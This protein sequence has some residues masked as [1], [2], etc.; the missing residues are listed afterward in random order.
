MMDFYNH[1]ENKISSSNPEDTSTFEE[2]CRN[3]YGWTFTCDENGRYTDCSEEI[4]D[5]LGFSP[6]VFL[7]EKF[8]QTYL[9][10]ESIDQIY[11]ALSSNE[12]PAVVPTYFVDRR[13]EQIPVTLTLMNDTQNNVAGFRGF[14]QVVL[15]SEEIA[16]PVTGGE[17]MV[18]DPVETQYSGT[19]FS[20]TVAYT[21]A[22]YQQASV[23]L[24]ELLEKLQ[25]ITPSIKTA[26]R[27]R[28]VSR[29][30]ISKYAD[31]TALPE[32]TELLGKE[33]YS[34]PEVKVL[35]VEHRLEWG[36]KLGLSNSE[37]QYI[38]EHKYINGIVGRFRVRLAP[39][40][41]LLCRKQWIQ[42]TLRIEHGIRD[43]LI[44]NYGNNQEQVFDNVLDLLITE[45]ETLLPLLTTILKKPQREEKIAIRGLDYLIPA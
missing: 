44:L 2:I 4:E 11:Q 13:G 5:V 22:D 36:E 41:I 31:R 16:I 6:T 18:E 39:E 15:T 1:L 28:I 37:K 20:A 35:T 9:Q 45:P 30:H 25:V 42:A 3:Y 32:I 27:S 24:K 19:V 33:V 29:S 8:T 14:V 10:P 7:G 34:Y 12:L 21:E 26:P 23:R 40:Q 38:D 17:V 43:Q